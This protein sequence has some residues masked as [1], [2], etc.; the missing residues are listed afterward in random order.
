MRRH[1][2]AAAV[3]AVSS[4]YVVGSA[5]SAA[6]TVRTIGAASVATARCTNA[7][8]TMVP[9]LSGSAVASVAVGGLPAACGGATLRVTV[10]DGTVA[11]SG[12]AT[13]PAAGGSVAVTIASSP[14]LNAHV[15]I[16][17]VLE[18]P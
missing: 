5:A 8:L 3:L 14:A 11:G 2:I 13:V 17:A 7:G 18:G 15:E 10:N 9:T 12:S 4:G 16:D 1:L 6:L